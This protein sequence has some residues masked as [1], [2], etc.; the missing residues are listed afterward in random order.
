MVSYRMA[1]YNKATVLKNKLF[2]QTG[3]LPYLC[4]KSNKNVEKPIFTSYR[5]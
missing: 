4:N 2:L 3:T 1:I 5:S